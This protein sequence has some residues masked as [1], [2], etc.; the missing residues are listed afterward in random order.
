MEAL[1]IDVVNDLATNNYTGLRYSN[2]IL[3]L[4]S[5]S[6]LTINQPKSSD[7]AL[8]GWNSLASALSVSPLLRSGLL[9]VYSR[10]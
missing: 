8:L 3:L 6:D 7:A 1:C 10:G 2:F 9:Q 4:T 5:N